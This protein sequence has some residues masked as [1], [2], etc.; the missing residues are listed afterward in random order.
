MKTALLV[1]D[2]QNALVNEGPYAW[3]KVNMNIQKL[4]GEA[5]ENEIEVIFVQHIGSDGGE[6]EQGSIGGEIFKDV[7]P[8]TSEKV[9][10]KRFNSAFKETG[11]NEYLREQ[12]ISKLVVT[13]MQTE[14]CIDTSCKV[15]FEYGYE[16]I[17]PEWTNTT[18]DSNLFKAEDIYKHYNFNIFKDRFAVVEDVCKTLDRFKGSKV[19]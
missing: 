17:V 7:A 14:F 13:G 9:F 12:N 6:L 1:I 3:E 18:Y 11:L 15:A 5:R 16:L 10:T 8:K 19:E 4:I 2:V